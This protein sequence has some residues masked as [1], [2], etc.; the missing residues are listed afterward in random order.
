[1]AIHYPS[2]PSVFDN[3]RNLVAN[4]ELSAAIDDFRALLSAQIGDH[5]DARH[6]K[7]FNE[8]LL[9]AATL[10][11]I[12]SERRLGVSSREEFDQGVARIT[13][14]ILDLI[15]KSEV[16]SIVQ[17][18][19]IPEEPITSSGIDP[20]TLEVIVGKNSQLKSLSWLHQAL[21]CARS[22]CRV[23]V[24]R[25]V[26][27][28]FITNRNV[29][30]TNNHVIR[31]AQD[32]ERAVIEFNFEED[33]FGNLKQVARY[34]VDPGILLTDQTLDCTIG[35]ILPSETSGNLGEWGTLAI[36]DKTTIKTGDH[37]T[38]IQ[39]PLGGLKQ[40]CLTDNRVVNI[41]GAFLQYTTDTMRGSSGSPVFNDEW[42]VVAIH[43]AGGDL[44]TN[45]KGDTDFL[46]EG[47]LMS[48]IMAR[49]DFATRIR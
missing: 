31:D 22:V 17:R 2:R 27:T 30:V 7:I 19:P 15:S 9:H 32:A 29:L 10:S 36:E 14:A 24:P 49:P 37:V 18:V 42:K 38:I 25:G 35:T 28:G 41:F 46:N 34:K 20:T 3:L 44:V 45:K 8:V 40:V 47:I 26:G 12:S 33:L 39:H 48:S 4:G 21:K 1:M 16:G 23:V 13:F 6:E 11:R 43:H 5:Q